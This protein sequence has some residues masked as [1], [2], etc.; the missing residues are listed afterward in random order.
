MVGLFDWIHG[1]LVPGGRVIFGNFHPANPTRAVMDHLLDWKLIHRDEPAM[2][3]LAMRSKFG[4][5]WSGIQ[6]EAQRINLF[7]ELTR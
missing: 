7:A 1:V 6:L 5:A 2:H 3:R 4:R